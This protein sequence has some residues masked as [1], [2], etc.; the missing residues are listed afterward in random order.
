MKEE[1]GVNVSLEK[2]VKLPASE[3][4]GQEFIW[5]YRGKLA[6]DIRPDRTEIEAGAFFKPDIVDGWIAA[7]PGDFAPG[8]AECWKAYRQHPHA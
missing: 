6:G 3:Q 2:M 7:R 4:T 8:F 5:L 1:L